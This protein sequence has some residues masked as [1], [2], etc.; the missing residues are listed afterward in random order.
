MLQLPTV[1]SALAVANLA[2]APD[3][4]AYLAADVLVSWGYL[5]LAEPMLERLRRN[6]EYAP[7]VHRL[8]A[9]ARQLRR[10]GILEDVTALNESGVSID[11][12]HEA[13][14][15][16]H[17][18]G[19]KKAIIVFTGLG[20][21][22]WLS[23]MVLHAFLKRLGTHIIYLTDLRHLIFFDGLETVARGYDGLLAA[24]RD[25]VRALAVEDVHVMG[26]SAGGFMALRYAIDL[27]AR[28]FLGMSIRTDLSPGTELPLA[29]FF[30]GPELAAY[31]QMKIDL[32]PLLRRSRAPE[33]IMLFCGDG[34]PVDLPHALHLADL[35]NVELTVLDGYVN[36]DVI[37]GLLG[38]GLFEPVLH[39]FIE[40]GPVRVPLRHI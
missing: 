16:R 19:S 36:H 17:T 40:P 26:N 32:K 31:P 24:L 25:T 20:P 6:P 4:D 10:S 23:L 35:P 14:T 11:G 30:T 7:R 15:A 1:E 2:D 21:R 39:R 27:G 34:N 3:A 29:E 8:A 38:R 13:Y 12:R 37:S 9:A 33:R 22:F 28:T 18:A 5:D